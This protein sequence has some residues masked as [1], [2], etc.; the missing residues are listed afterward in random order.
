M[1]RI[2]KEIHSPFSNSHIFWKHLLSN[3]IL[4]LYR[5]FKENIPRKQYIKFSSRL[6]NFFTLKKS[7]KFLK[8]CSNRKFLRLRSNFFLIFFLF[9]HFK[10]RRIISVIIHLKTVIAKMS[11]HEGV[12][13]TSRLLKNNYHRV[14]NFNGERNPQ[15]ASLICT[16]EIDRYSR[17]DA[18]EIKRVE[19][20]P[21]VSAKTL[22][23]IY[24]ETECMITYCI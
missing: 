13:Y 12:P 10:K 21:R 22:K 9:V 23:T 2:K 3:R 5:T 1:K 4:Y 17:G 15:P 6:F 11:S 8:T 18:I 16:A 20:K 24:T 14:K 19:D 7:F